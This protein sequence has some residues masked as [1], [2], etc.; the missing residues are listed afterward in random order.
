M[1]K[2]KQ[3]ILID[4]L[5]LLPTLGV[6]VSKEIEE[7]IKIFRK[8]NIF[9]IEAG[10]LEA[11]WVTLKVASKSKLNRI[12]LGLEAIRNSYIQLEPPI[13]TYIDA[14]EIYHK[15]HRDYIDALHY[16]AAWKTQTPF[17]TVDKTFIEFLRENNYS[18]EG[19]IITPSELKV[20]A[21]GL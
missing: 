18:V 11:M 13:Q 2:R 15:G 7:A 4:T 5:F 8:F 10:I 12:K 17:L 14:I 3:N 1:K 6:G 20:I 9:Y 21:E 16:A 19:T